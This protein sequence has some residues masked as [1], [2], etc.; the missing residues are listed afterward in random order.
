MIINTFYPGMFE[1]YCGPMKSGKTRE[2]LN[3]VDKLRYMDNCK[4][5]FLKQTQTQETTS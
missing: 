4:F 3:R 2:M 5:L 1:L